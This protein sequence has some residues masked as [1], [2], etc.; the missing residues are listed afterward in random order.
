MG[1]KNSEM[2]DILD[3]TNLLKNKN[4][5]SKKTILPYKYKKNVSKL[6]RL[7]AVIK[8]MKNNINLLKI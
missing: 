8:D 3:F 7:G 4:K 6:H 5:T 2:D 1:K